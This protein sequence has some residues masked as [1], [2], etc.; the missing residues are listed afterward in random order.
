[1]ET[2]A[3]HCQREL[4]PFSVFA[5]SRPASPMSLASLD[6]TSLVLTS[7]DSR[8]PSA[9][10]VFRYQTVMTSCAELSTAGSA[11]LLRA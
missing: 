4:N 7:L 11:L 5:R 6:D 3:M 8:R 2:A 1:M 9:T 10:L